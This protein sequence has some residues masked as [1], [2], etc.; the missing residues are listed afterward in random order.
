MCSKVTVQ[1]NV[2]SAEKYLRSN[3]K[4][5]N[6]GLFEFWNDR[7]GGK[8][9]DAKNFLLQTRFTSKLKRLKTL[10]FWGPRRLEFTTKYEMKSEIAIKR[11]YR[12]FWTITSERTD[13]FFYNG[14]RS[15]EN[16]IIFQ[17]VYTSTHSES[18]EIR[19]EM[20]SKLNHFLKII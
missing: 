9:L 6:V 20:K 2:S 14:T 11:G 5:F 16:L 3:G 8:I 10:S 18:I 12:S 13:E 4:N 17:S 7:N 1:E 19:N 15:T